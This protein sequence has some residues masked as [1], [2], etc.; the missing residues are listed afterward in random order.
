MSELE[1]RALDA[2][3]A[4]AEHD[5]PEVMNTEEQE[6]AEEADLDAESSDIDSDSDS[7]SDSDIDSDSD[8]DSESDEEREYPEEVFVPETKEELIKAIIHS[9]TDNLNSSCLDIYKYLFDLN[10]ATYLKNED[11]IKNINPPRK[12]K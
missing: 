12:F 4:Q 6:I 1:P 8:S 7:D 9:K 2:A 10:Q 3:F 11:I 5:E